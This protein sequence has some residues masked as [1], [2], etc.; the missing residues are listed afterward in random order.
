MPL[1]SC[2]IVGTG[3]ED[4]PLRP[5]FSGEDRRIGWICLGPP[6]SSAGRGLLWLPTDTTDS[7]I[8]KIADLPGERPTNGIRNVLQNE[9]GITL[10]SPSTVSLATVIAEILRDHG[11]TDGTRW[12]ILQPSK[13]RQQFEIHLGELGAIWTQAAVVGPS[14]QSFSETWPTNGDTISTGQDQ[15][16]T[17]LTNSVEVSSGVL[18]PTSTAVTY[19]RCDSSLD[20]SAQYHQ[21]DFTLTDGVTLSNIAQPMVRFTDL[22]NHYR[23]VARRRSTTGHERVGAKRVASTTT[24]IVTGDTT[25]PG[26]SGTIKVTIDGSTMTIDIGAYNSSGTDGTPEL[27]AVLTGG[28]SLFSQGGVGQ[29]TADNHT[30][31]DVVAAGRTTRNTRAFPLGTEIGMG[32]VM[33]TQV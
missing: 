11:R 33:P 1:Y 2:A 6:G 14:T 3:A 17:E 30:I 28:V 32:W 24:T 10:A 29:A 15:A 26:A 20:T 23:A 9:L 7:R 13:L 27:T 18:R 5:P 16:W 25:D 12:G 21:F 8:R 19:A 31:A 4:D 22:N